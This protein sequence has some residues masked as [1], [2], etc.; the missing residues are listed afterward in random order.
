MTHKKQWTFLVS[1][2]PEVAYSRAGAE[3]I[4]DDPGIFCYARKC[5]KWWVMSQ[6]QISLFE[7]TS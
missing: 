7:G 3:N 2:K 5:Q 1:L 4:Q 6:E